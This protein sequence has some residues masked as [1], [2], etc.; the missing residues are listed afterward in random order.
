MAAWRTEIPSTPFRESIWVLPQPPFPVPFCLDSTG[1]THTDSKYYFN[2]DKGRS[3]YVLEYII[4][5]AGHLLIEG[6]HYHLKAGGVYLLPPL[7]PH[8]YYANPKNPWQKIWFNIS[9][10]LIDHLAADYHL[11]G[12]IYLSHCPL[13]ADFRRGIE[14]VRCCK[15]DVY[16][17]LAVLVHKIIATI[18]HY[19]SLDP[20]NQLSPE[21]LQLKH[22]LD[23]HWNDTIPLTVLAHLIGKSVPQMLRIF[24]R[25]WHCTPGQYLQ[26]RK[27]EITVQYLEN[28]AYM[29]RE[30]AEIVGFANEFY[31][32]NWFKRK[33]GM[34]PRRFRQSK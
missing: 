16:T 33:I 3:Y 25:D 26:Q 23:S 18:A 31:F 9:G 24:R 4:A 15:A 27:L 22:Y 34:S 5:G 17:E 28:T 20:H 30:I 1:I 19:R 13:E 2:C 10:E 6:H 11:A 29:I 21:S 14:I 32:S 12:T 7:V 8:K